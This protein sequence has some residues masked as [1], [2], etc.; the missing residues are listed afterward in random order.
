MF[1]VTRMEHVG[2]IAVDSGQLEENM[3]EQLHTEL[4]QL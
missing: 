2:A 3:S 1:G 4:T